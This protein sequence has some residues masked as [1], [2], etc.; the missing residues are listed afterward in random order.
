MEEARDNRG[1]TISVSHH[2]IAARD[3]VTE[4]LFLAKAEGLDM[5]EYF[6]NEFD[7]ADLAEIAKAAEGEGL[8]VS[9]HPW[10]NLAALKRSREIEGCLEEII[11][12]AARMG[13]ENI[14][15][16]LGEASGSDR[17]SCLANVVEGFCLAALAAQDAGVVF[18]V[19]NVYEWTPGAMGDRFK[20]FESLFGHIDSKT[21]GMTFDTGH[22][23]ITGNITE[24]IEV[25][26]K[27]VRHVHLHSNDTT[28]DQHRGLGHGDL[29]WEGAVGKLL[30]LGF[31]GPFNL[32]FPYGAEGGSEVRDL[33]RRLGSR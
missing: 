27:R 5:V 9:W 33:I 26:G 32:E 25:F 11:E 29:D 15:V 28:A 6:G 16:H 1:V 18:C 8:A 2:C 23:L 4:A 3:S 24:W 13:A 22:A 21:L 19:E 17:E 20:D 31:R 10:L 30:E 14:V 7:A 12:D